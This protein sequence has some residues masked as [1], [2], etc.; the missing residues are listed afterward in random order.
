VI[1]LSINDPW[2]KTVRIDPTQVTRVE[3]ECPKPFRDVVTD[4]IYKFTSITGTKPTHLLVHPQFKLV[5]KSETL[6][7]QFNPD[8]SEIEQYLGMRLI[9]TL[10][11]G[12][13]LLCSEEA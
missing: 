4:G 10:D 9:N 11:V 2:P 1:L 3:I 12:L 5:L 6:I 13:E 8:A 7:M